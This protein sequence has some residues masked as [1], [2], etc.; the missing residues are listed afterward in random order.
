MSTCSYFHN[1][2]LT[3]KSEMSKQC[4]ISNYLS[5]LENL[6]QTRRYD[7]PNASYSNLSTQACSIVKQHKH[8]ATH[9]CFK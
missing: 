8:H 4:K 9:T 2:H 6:H 7:N 5:T 3:L 1:E